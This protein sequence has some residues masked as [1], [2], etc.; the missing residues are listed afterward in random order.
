VYKRQVKT[1]RKMKNLLTTVFAL[2]LGVSAFAQEPVNLKFN[3]EK[4]RVNQLRSI[5]KQSVQ[6]TYNGTP[7]KT[8]V[9][10]A[11]T[12]SFTLLSQEN[13]LMRIEFKFDT[14]QSKTTSPMRN[15]ETNSTKP[16][17]KTEYLEKALNRF[18][19]YTII[20]KI[21]TKGKFQG[22][23][24]YKTF[25]DN[26]LVAMDSVPEGKKDQIQKQVDMLLKESVLQTMIEPLFSYM[27]ENP[28]KKSDKWETSYSLVGGGI[29]GMMFNTYTLDEVSGNNAQLSVES[30]LE[31]VPATAENLNMNIDIKGKSNGTLSVDLKTGIIKTSKDKKHYEGI[32]TMKSQGNEMKMP[33]VIDAESE[34]IRLK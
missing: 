34:I 6:A 14:I 4:G 17:K 15:F 3:L 32:M 30:E 1:K 5:S 19:T 2:F 9:N 18:S 27:P 29:T 24:N 26:V 22:F 7:F 11:T 23:E 28:V 12:T 13:D 16:A 25:R 8:D 31:S 33:M 10:S 21:S 20:A